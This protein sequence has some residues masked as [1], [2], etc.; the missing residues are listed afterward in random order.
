M[1]DNGLD[2]PILRLALPSLLA[3]ISVPLIGLVDTA[4][5]GHLSDVAFLGAVATASLL[6]DV[7][8]WS[9]GFLR[10][11]TTSIVSQYYGA[12]DRANCTATLY[13]ALLLAAMIGLLVLL[14]RDPLSEVGFVLVGGTDEVQIWGQRYFD[15]RVFGV[16]LVL[17]TLALNGFFLGVANAVAPLLITVVANVVNVA[18][19]YALIFGHWGAP[20]LGVVGAAWASVLANGVG[21]V[22]GLSILLARYH[23]NLSVA[24]PAGL[25]DLA[26][27]RHLFDTNVNLLGRTLCLLFAQFSLVALVARMGD[28]PLAAHT[29]VWQLWA[30]VS[31]GVDGFAHAAEALVGSALGSGDSTRARAYARRILGWGICIGLLF[32]VVYAVRLEFLVRIL[33]SHAEVAVAAGGLTILVAVMQPLNAVVF[34]FDGIFIGA[35]DMA[36]MFRAMAF[37]AFAFFVPAAVVLVI[38]LDGGLL[39]AWIAYAALMVG[40]ALPLALRYRTDTWLRTFV[41]SC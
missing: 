22:V 4:M 18:A 14:L 40:R 21:F 35:N 37:A 3:A 12:G 39:S 19:D 8:F 17:A 31:Y 26:G 16:P 33:T 29:V 41:H 28:V 30:L 25:L 9:A 20:E 32:T 7:L 38:W 1:T 24:S 27:L 11:G 15:V 6:F 10:M 2:R 5:V 34:I 36:Y 23:P 13:R